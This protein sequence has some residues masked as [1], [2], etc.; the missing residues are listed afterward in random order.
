MLDLESQGPANDLV[1]VH[2]I[3][4]RGLV[5]IHANVHE[6]GLIPLSL[7]GQA[8]LPGRSDAFAVRRGRTD[9]HQ[10]QLQGGDAH[11]TP[12]TPGEGTHAHSCL[13]L[14]TSSMSGLS[15]LA[16]TSWLAHHGNYSKVAFE[17]AMAE[18]SD[19]AAGHHDIIRCSTSVKRDYNIWGVDFS[20]QSTAAMTTRSQATIRDVSLPQR[21]QLQTLL[22]A[23]KAESSGL[24]LEADELTVLRGKGWATGTV[25]R[26]SATPTLTPS[27]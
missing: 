13:A 25:A 18:G 9:H 14:T 19:A 16:G 17:K 27:T 21:V 6:H 5:R 26:W 11:G 22:F 23:N 4:C 15:S 2:K 8:L 12:G 3:F 20:L 10:H 24:Q 7:H 1:L